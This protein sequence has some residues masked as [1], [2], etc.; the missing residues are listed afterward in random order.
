MKHG[1][2][3]LG[4][5]VIRGEFAQKLFGRQVQ[6]RRIGIRRMRKDCH[7]EWE[8]AAAFHMSAVAGLPLAED[9]V[10]PIDLSRG[11]SPVN[12]IGDAI[13]ELGY[14]ERMRWHGAFPG[15]GG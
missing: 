1:I 11:D 12:R 5:H 10:E 7:V 13:R 9:R 14:T 8:E 6:E 2:A 4:M 15:Y 3:K